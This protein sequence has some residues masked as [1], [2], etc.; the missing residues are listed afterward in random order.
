MDA[1][2]RDLAR[3]FER[4]RAVEDGVAWL[5]ARLRVDDVTEDDLEVAALCGHA[6]ARAIVLVGE[7]RRLTTEAMA[8]SVGVSRPTLRGWARRGCPSARAEDGAYRFDPVEVL[9]WMAAQPGLASGD[10]V[11]ALLD[12]LHGPFPLVALHAACMLVTRVLDGDVGGPLFQSLDAAA[13]LL[14]PVVLPGI[15][16]P[17]TTPSAWLPA[18][19]DGRGRGAFRED[20]EGFGAMLRADL[21]AWALAPGPRS[22]RLIVRVWHD[23]P[24]VEP[25]EERELIAHHEVIDRRTGR[26]VREWLEQGFSR[27]EGDQWSQPRCQGA[28]KVVLAPD[29][30]RVTVHHHGGRVEQVAVG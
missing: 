2:L 23:A 22:P 15:L 27:W 29:G 13:G 16:W 9:G 4:S 21:I 11:Y 7:R 3:R 5:T 25:E 12:L 30:R 26:V 18:H 19:L 1:D 6:A 28:A 14:G 8:W 24:R 10:P 20:P 17:R